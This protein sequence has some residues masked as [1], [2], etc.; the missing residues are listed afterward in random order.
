M[1]SMEMSGGHLALE[2]VLLPEDAVSYHSVLEM[3]TTCSPP[4]P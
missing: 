4:D 3:L 2:R 1:V